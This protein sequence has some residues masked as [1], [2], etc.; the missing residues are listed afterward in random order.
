MRAET[1]RYAPA[2]NEASRKLFNAWLDAASRF[3]VVRRLL[4]AGALDPD[5]LAGLGG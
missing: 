4:G 2:A 5:R 3:L 1:A